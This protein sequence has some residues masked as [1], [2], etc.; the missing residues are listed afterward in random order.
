MAWTLHIIIAYIKTGFF[1]MSI[2]E[3]NRPIQRI[4]KIYEKVC[5]PE[6]DGFAGFTIYYGGDL[7]TN[8]I[9]FFVRDTH[10]QISRQV[11]SAHAEASMAC[12][13][14]IPKDE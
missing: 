2:R 10:A 3:L 11:A 8:H 4:S 7:F 5:S 13:P 14:V 12:C 6:G 9:E 1:E